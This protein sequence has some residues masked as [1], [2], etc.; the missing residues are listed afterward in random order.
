MP[1]DNRTDVSERIYVNKTKALKNA[2]FATNSIF[3]NTRV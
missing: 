1:Y 3:L 2:L